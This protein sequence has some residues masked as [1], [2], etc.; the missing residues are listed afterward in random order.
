MFKELTTFLRIKKMP[1]SPLHRLIHT[2]SRENE[3]VAGKRTDKP[4]LNIDPIYKITQGHRMLK[5]VLLIP[6]FLKEWLEFGHN[7]TNMFLRHGKELI[8]SC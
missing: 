1:P 3:A 8:I 7:W 2:S 6:Y 5:N 4:L